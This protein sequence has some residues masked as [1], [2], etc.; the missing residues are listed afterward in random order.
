[1]NRDRQ[2][3][4]G[5]AMGIDHDHCLH[6]FVAGILRT[7]REWVAIA[8]VHQMSDDGFT[9]LGNGPHKVRIDGDLVFM[10]SCGVTTLED[11]H[12]LRVLYE[13]VR[14]E[15]NALFV[16]YDSRAGGGVDRAARKYLLEPSPNESRPDAA[17]TFGARFSSRILISMIDRALIA[18]GKAPSGVAMFDTEDEA[19]AYLERERIR[20][21]D[22]RAAGSVSP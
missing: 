8:R 10:R 22:Q 17:A 3:W 7:S 9:Q 19:R 15:Q 12:A 21:K 14:R 18:F 1:M 2:G 5:R 6:A 20:L 16:L 11:L 13:R 4:L